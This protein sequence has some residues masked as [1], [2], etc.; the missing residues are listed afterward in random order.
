MV[1]SSWVKVTKPYV[2]RTSVRHKIHGK[3]FPRGNGGCLEAATWPPASVDK[4][5]MCIDGQPHAMAAAASA[6]VPTRG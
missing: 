6:K 3:G 1:P 2:G 5:E 4:H